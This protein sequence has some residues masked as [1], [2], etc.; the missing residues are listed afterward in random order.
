M[1]AEQSDEE[2]EKKKRGKQ[3]R[4]PKAVAAAPSPNTLRK[5]RSVGAAELAQEDEP[6]K[7]SKKAEDK[8]LVTVHEDDE[9]DKEGGG[10][11]E[12]GDDVQAKKDTMQRTI[13]KDDD[14][15]NDMRRTK[16]DMFD[17]TC[18]VVLVV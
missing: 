9:K 17:I 11:D 5:G 2:D 6:I 15:D 18:D 3:G 4:K 12:N 13:A 1:L 7:K 16:H 10:E 8:K 14:Y